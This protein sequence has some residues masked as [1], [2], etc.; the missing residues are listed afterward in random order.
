MKF[1][2]TTKTMVYCALFAAMQV[3][4]EALTQITPTMPKGGNIS[5]S[6]VIIFLCGYLLS[7]KYALVVSM[8]CL[9]LHFA[10]GFSTYYGMA[11]LFFDY[12]IPMIVIA[13]STAIP[14]FKEKTI[15]LPLGIIFALVVKTACHVFVG[16][17]AFGYTFQGSL[18]Y[19]L[20]YNIATMVTCVVL[21]ML[22]YPTLKKVIR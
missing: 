1:E 2:L 12:I 4:L 22:T 18:A 20:P 14:L 17:Y 5:F 11:S 3:V 10:L 15:G 21:F 16:W 9:G 6:L 7:Y 13:L 8:I 19:N